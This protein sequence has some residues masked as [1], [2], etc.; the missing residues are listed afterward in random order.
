MA[1]PRSPLKEFRHLDEK[2][3]AVGLSAVERARWESLKAL[4][5]PEAPA[6]AGG[7]F[8]VDAAARALRASLLP[9]GLR[10]A[11][12]PPEPARSPH[13]PRP[14][15]GGPEGPPPRPP[16]EWQVGDAR[17][18]AP[19][20]ARADA[21]PAEAPASP[22]LI[23]AA[24]VAVPWDMGPM[25]PADPGF[26]PNAPPPDG[27]AWDASPAENA[28]PEGDVARWEAAVQASPDASPEPGQAGASPE[29][30][31]LGDPGAWG[32]PPPGEAP[33][34]ADGSWDP[35]SLACESQ[36][37]A[38][39][40]PGPT[41]GAPSEASPS[42]FDPSWGYGGRA[43][44]FQATRVE[45][46]SWEAAASG[47]ESA[48]PAAEAP[49]PAEAPAE[50]A[51]TG[52]PAPDVGGYVEFEAGAE[53]TA[54]RDP[55]AEGI[56]LQPGEME[57][58][59]ATQAE[60]ASW[61]AAAEDAIPGPV[62]APDPLALDAPPEGVPAPAPDADGY[63][64]FE[65]AAS[66]AP[67]PEAG[68]VAPEVPLEG[69]AAPPL[70]EPGAAGT[71][72]ED[73]GVEEFEAAAFSEAES[74]AI[75]RLSEAARAAPVEFAAE[76]LPGAEMLGE[77]PFGELDG[78]GAASPAEAPSPEEAAPAGAASS[79]PL[80]TEEQVETFS[81]MADE[82]G[83][84]GRD[85]SA[86][87]EEARA[88]SIEFAPEAGD[89]LALASASEFLSFVGD[90]P[91]GVVSLEHEQSR[92]EGIEEL[93][94]EDIEEIVEEVPLDPAT[95]ASLE[96]LPEMP[97]PA[98]EE[99]GLGGL[100][101]A[102]A[103]VSPAEDLSLDPSNAEVVSLEEIAI[104]P[105]PPHAEALATL[106]PSPP[107]AQ[108][109]APPLEAPPPA[110]VPPVPAPP[111]VR[112]AEVRPAPAAATPPPLSPMAEERPTVPPAAARPAPAFRVPARTPLLTSASEPEDLPLPTGPE[113]EASRSSLVQGEHRVVVHTVEGQ[114]LR[115]VLRDADLVAAAVPLLEASGETTG[116]AAERVKAI[117]F[118]L[119]PGQ[120]PPSC[121][122]TKVRV[123][124]GD[125]RQ[126][127]GMSPDYSPSAPG[128]F[129]VPVDTRTNTARIWVYRAA[130]RQI[131]VG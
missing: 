49:P 76:P 6:P 93:A 42:G 112:A 117:F 84:P 15:S 70:A 63:V 18:Q 124:F 44:L 60:L 47:A 81:V 77:V 131:S 46:A 58:F 122:G 97:P 48:E 130:A 19:E 101:E 40:A 31:D 94:A 118:M 28:A 2:L 7:G 37:Q 50:E 95:A 121:L 127:A 126:I 25:A 98:A 20:P 85:D 24:E 71:A 33:P 111:A 5:A 120:A 36:P 113:E 66:W 80:F 61:E 105:P 99:E 39:E 125:G 23:P 9:A 83:G 51:P 115:G 74:G 34:L 68:A 64:E 16:G 8:D 29:A 108:E 110:P 11:A 87:E 129:V 128:F 102:P 103:E 89:G 109:A 96:A 38:W 92:E 78:E 35:Q 116:V 43:E 1:E 41:E 56:D 3:H 55:G 59:Q 53:G 106:L 107:P 79:D 69:E 30:V 12:P 91:P 57:L 73:L 114:V 88:R 45:L 52:E 100:V 75:A 104:T 65:T 86:A 90:S 21:L 26:D 123:T 4:V 10:T 13:S 32:A 54:A 17:R 82:I 67:A 27:A 119:D 62:P 72:G 22:E 14:T